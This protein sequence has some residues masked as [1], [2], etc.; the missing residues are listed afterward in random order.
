MRFVSHNINNNH[1]N[2]KLT[3]LKIGY[4]LLVPQLGFDVVVSLLIMMIEATVASKKMVTSLS[5][6]KC[7]VVVHV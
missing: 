7:S 6:S 4:T 3:D 5:C 2:I 1:T